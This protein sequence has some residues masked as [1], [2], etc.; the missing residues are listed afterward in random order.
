MYPVSVEMQPLSIISLLLLT[1]NPVFALIQ[2]N[3]ALGNWVSAQRAKYKALNHGHEK[4]RTRHASL[5]QTRLQALAAVGFVW[6]HPTSQDRWDERYAQLQAYQAVHGHCNVPSTYKVSVDLQRLRWSHLIGVQERRL[7]VLFLPAS[8]TGSTAALVPTKMTAVYREQQQPRHW[9]E[10]RIP[11]ALPC[12][13]PIAENDMTPKRR[14]RENRF[15][16]RTFAG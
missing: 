15:A 12:N 5:T 9:W 11:S 6:A 14:C 2:E 1:L 3:P 8:V 10:L 13:Q 16:Q 4:V 7:G